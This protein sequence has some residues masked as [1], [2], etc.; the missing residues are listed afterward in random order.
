MPRKYSWLALVLV[1]LALEAR[2]DPPPANEAGEDASQVILYMTSWC[3]YCRLTADFLTG[4]GVAFSERNIETD[5]KA[6]GEYMAAG[7]NGGVPMVIIGDTRIMG[8]DVA[9]MERA[10]AALPTKTDPPPTEAPPPAESAPKKPEGKWPKSVQGAAIDI[11]GNVHEPEVHYVISRED[12]SDVAS[13][14]L[15]HDPIEAVA[16][17][18]DEDE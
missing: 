8:Y 2:A 4:K 10:L 11:E 15:E 5:T 7:G 3:H 9:G 18:T 13:V 14:D 6:L 17:E 1:A 12:T 16:G